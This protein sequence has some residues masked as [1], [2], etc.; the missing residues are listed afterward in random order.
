MSEC[1]VINASPIILLAK[2]GLIHFVPLIARPLVI[3]D[4]VAAEIRECREV[5]AAV[6]WTEGDGKQFIRSAVDELID[7]RTADIGPGER[8]VISW[9]AANP[10]FVAVLDDAEARLAARS[11]GVPVLG[12][13]GIFLNLKKAGLITEI[14]THLANIRR[15]GGYISD[16]LFR[17]ALRRAAEQS[18]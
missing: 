17:E 18:D 4:P 11:L 1:W 8:S 13:V 7:L 9:V 6:R 10:G 3:P 14:T 5:D 2:A 15:V 12:T 16:S